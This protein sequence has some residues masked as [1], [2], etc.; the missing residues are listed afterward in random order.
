MSLRPHILLILITTSHRL[1]YVFSFVQTDTPSLG[2]D[3]DQFIADL[4][5]HPCGI[6]ADV[7]VC[8]ALLK[9]LVDKG[10]VFLKPLLDVD[11]FLRVS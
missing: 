1:D 6:T 4:A 2:N 3:L 8:F 9:K 5:C 10:R 7:E 11:L